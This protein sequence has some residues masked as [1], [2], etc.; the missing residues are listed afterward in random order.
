VIA[1]GLAGGF[2][3][4]SEFLTTVQ[5]LEHLL[6]VRREAFCTGLAYGGAIGLAVGVVSA[7]RILLIDRGSCGNPAPKIARG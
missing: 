1:I 3:I 2:A 5:T 7:T 4:A 6:P